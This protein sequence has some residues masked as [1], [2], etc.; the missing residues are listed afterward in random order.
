MALA[1]IPAHAASAAIGVAPSGARPACVAGQPTAA[2]YTWDFKAE[3]NQI[4][5]Q[6][7]T[8]ARQVTDD[9]AQLESYSQSPELS[10]E[11]RVYELSH[12]SNPVNDIGSKLCRLL[13]IRRVVS[14]DQQQAI[15]RIAAEVH[16]MV[17]HAQDAY[18]F[19]RTHYDGFFTRPYRNDV[20]SLYDEASAVRHSVHNEL[21]A[22][23]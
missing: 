6:I 10:S 20:Q 9:A 5:K 23:L 21:R 18:N 3:A 12:L 19:A 8:D 16:L 11:A 2:S 14:P 15:D 7:R 17:F 13:T 4:F 1:A 22:S